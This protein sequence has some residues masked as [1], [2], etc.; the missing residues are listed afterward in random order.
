MLRPVGEELIDAEPAVLGVAAVRAALAAHW[1]RRSRHACPLARDY[2]TGPMTYD[3]AII[4]GGILGLAT[5]R[6]LLERFPSLS[7]VLCEKEAEL[8]THQTGHNSGV[9]HSGIYYKPG[10]LKAE[11]CVEGREAGREFCDEHGIKYDR[12]GKVIVATSPGGAA[13]PAH[14]LRA[15]AGQRRAGRHDDRR[16]A[17]ARDRAARAGP[18]PGST[19]PTP[20]SSTTARWRRR[21]AR[22]GRRAA[23]TIE[24]NF[25]V[26]GDHRVRGG[27]RARL[28][29]TQRAISARRIVNCAGLL[30]RSR[31]RG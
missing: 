10:S 7:L 3:V 15:R 14:A 18:W 23:A 12:C 5:A 27:G 22:S 9:I 11:L 26:V 8:A 21:S 28:E 16:R 19:R 30:L 31:G 6:A 24:R 13:A 17:R 2:N 25:P 1:T 20:A 29:T 4:G